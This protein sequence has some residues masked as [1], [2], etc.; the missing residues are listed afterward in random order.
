[1]T[2]E[3]VQFDPSGAASHALDL[4]QWWLPATPIQFQVSLSRWGHDLRLRQK[5]GGEYFLTPGSSQGGLVQTPDGSWVESYYYFDATGYRR[6]MPG[7]DWWIYDATTAEY[8]PANT[9]D[10]TG[11]CCTPSP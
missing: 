6:D 4:S 10:L 1:M 9:S 8:A 3:N 5:D 7:V 2:G 11:W